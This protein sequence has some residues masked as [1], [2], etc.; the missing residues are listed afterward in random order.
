MLAQG[1]DQ[2]LAQQMAPETVNDAACD[3]RLQQ[4]PTLAMSPAQAL[5]IF[6]DRQQVYAVADGK[7][8]YPGD[9]LMN[10]WTRESDFPEI[11]ALLQQIR[12][13]W[14]EAGSP[15]SGS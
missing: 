14:V 1:E 10:Q 8:P 11:R 9:P 13:P 3:K 15:Q 12:S 6:P 7:E 2:W 5:S 4:Y